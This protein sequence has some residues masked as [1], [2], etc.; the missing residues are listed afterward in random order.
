MVGLSGASSIHVWDFWGTVLGP[1]SSLSWVSSG[2]L[3]APWGRMLG[4]LFGPLRSLLGRA[5]V[6]LRPMAGHFRANPIGASSWSRLGGL[7][8]RFGGLRGRLG[9]LL[10]LLGGPLGPFWGDL[11]G[12]SGRLGASGV[13]E[14]FWAV[15]G[16]ILGVSG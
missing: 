16:A 14:P 8:C 7:L 3:V 11:G 10:G 4:L 15:L 2:P 5:G 12:L 1:Q 9:A 6:A 13:S